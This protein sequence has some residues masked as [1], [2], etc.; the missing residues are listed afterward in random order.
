MKEGAL[1]GNSPAEVVMQCDMT[2]SCVS[3]PAALKDVS[4]FYSFIKYFSYFSPTH[5]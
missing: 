3:D 1:K 2:F 5:L 4:L